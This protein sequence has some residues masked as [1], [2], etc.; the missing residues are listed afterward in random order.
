MGNNLSGLRSMDLLN[1]SQGAHHH[2]P[3]PRD[4]ELHPNAL[5]GEPG[6]LD[7]PPVPRDRELH[8]NALAG[9]HRPTR[10]SQGTTS[11]DFLNNN[12]V[13]H[14][15]SLDSL[16]SEQYA[17]YQ[18]AVA[19][20]HTHGGPDFVPPPTSSTNSVEPVAPLDRRQ[21]SILKDNEMRPADHP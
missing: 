4:R 14:T 20:S 3:V 13:A 19:G 16:T 17:A 12:S 11:P 10:R 15:P 6:R 7:H 21:L 2:P 9:G 1:R 8:P 18:A 5:A